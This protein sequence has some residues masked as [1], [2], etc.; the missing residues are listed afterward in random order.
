MDLHM[1]VH[2]M[3]TTCKYIPK[4]IPILSHGTTRWDRHSGQWTYTYVQVYLVHESTFLRIPI[5][6]HGTTGWDRHSG[7]WTYYIDTYGYI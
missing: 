4:G 2:C 6:S 7:Q 1:H 5:L 3:C